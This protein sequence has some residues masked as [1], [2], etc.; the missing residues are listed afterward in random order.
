[1]RPSGTHRPAA[2][3]YASDMTA[4]VYTEEELLR[5]HPD[6]VPHVVAGRRMHGGFH[7]DGTYQPPRA[8]VRVPALAAWTQALIALSMAAPLRAA[9]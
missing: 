8:L 5:D 1:M 7:P 4:L 6:L 2:S 3:A 9:S